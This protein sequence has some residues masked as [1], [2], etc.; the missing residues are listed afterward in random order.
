MG[1]ECQTRSIPLD[2]GQY[3]FVAVQ[4]WLQ[5]TRAKPPS[6]TTG[7]ETTAPFYAASFSFGL[8]PARAANRTS[9]SMLNRSIL[10]RFRSDTR[11]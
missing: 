2:G 4:K 1:C 9:K 8:S 10:P 5:Q 3:L 7:S 11:A 6:A